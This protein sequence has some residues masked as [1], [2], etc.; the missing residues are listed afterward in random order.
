V[1]K[2]LLKSRR[3]DYRGAAAVEFAFVMIP[4]FVMII[5]MIEYG[6]YFYV[7]SNTSG[8][9]STVARKLQVGDC[10]SSG[11]ALAYAQN[12]APQ[13]T[14]ITISPSV[15]SAPD[16]G[17]S[18]SVTAQANAKLMDF[19]PLPGGGTV[20][21]IVTANVEDTTPSSC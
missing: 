6:W 16:V 20:T 2:K 5:G 10:W 3:R 18:F 1:L 4:F 17:T 11:A 14:S 19:L 7:A 21:R 12:Q 15:T 9:T 13:I 8:A